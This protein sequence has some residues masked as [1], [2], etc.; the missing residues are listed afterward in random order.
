MKDFML[1]FE[2][3]PWLSDPA[4]IVLLISIGLCLRLGS[5]LA[6]DGLESIKYLFEHFKA[7]FF[8]RKS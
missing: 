5:R 7:K 2:T 8:K 3:F 6:D 1:V 4:F